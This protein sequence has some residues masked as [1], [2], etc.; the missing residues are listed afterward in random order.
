M[1]DKMR[2]KKLPWPRFTGTEM[3]DLTAYLNRGHA[4][5]GADR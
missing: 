3:A 4:D 2:E 5:D 1:L